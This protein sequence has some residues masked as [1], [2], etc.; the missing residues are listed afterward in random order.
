MNLCLAAAAAAA[1]ACD[2]IYIVGTGK[3]TLNPHTIS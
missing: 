3:G 1:A 2:A